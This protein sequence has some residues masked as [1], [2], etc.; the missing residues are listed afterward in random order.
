MIDFIEQSRSEILTTNENLFKEQQELRNEMRSICEKKLP[1][2]PSKNLS[3]VSYLLFRSLARAAT[4]FD[5]S[6]GQ[7]LP[8]REDTSDSLPR[9]GSTSAFTPVERKSARRAKDPPQEIPI[10]EVDNKL[11][12]ER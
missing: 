6:S 5:L 2:I 12:V 8:L 11:A 3:A 10:D 1:V 4:S 7:C 9:S